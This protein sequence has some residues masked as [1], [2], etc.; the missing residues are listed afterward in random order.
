VEK[1]R[2][3]YFLEDNMATHF[4][5][6]LNG[7]IS[8]QH[9]GDINV[10]LFRTPYYGHERIII[11]PNVNVYEFDKVEFYDKNWK[12]KPVLQLIDEGLLPMPEGYVRE[13]DSLR[14]MTQEER[15]IAGLQELP[16]GLKVEKG[17]IVPMTQVERIDAGLDKLEPGFKIE[18]GEIVQMPLLEQFETGQITQAEYNQCLSDETTTELQRRLAELQTPEALAQAELNEVYAAERKAK[19]TALLA[20]KQQ[21]GWPVN[22]VWPE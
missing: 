22:I 19:L 9:C 16:P 3:N 6:V 8:G 12:R 5:T 14:P 2:V 21:D 1:D 17:E 13:G 18:N 20:V 11:P 15:I 4:I 7:V 10:D